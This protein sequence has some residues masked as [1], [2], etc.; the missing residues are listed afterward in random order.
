[1]SSGRQGRVGSGDWCPAARA[2]LAGRPLP[3]RIPQ[4]APRHPCPTPHGGVPG[5]AT[6]LPGVAKSFSAAELNWQPLRGWRTGVEVPSFGQVFVNDP[7]QRCGPTGLV[8][9]A[10]H[11]GQRVDL[12]SLDLRR[13]RAQWDTC[14]TCS[15]RRIRLRATRATHAISSPHPAGSSRSS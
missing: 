5:L 15:L 8:G 12:G 10:A 3:D 1:L 7:Q 14:S 6:S 2:D 13:R 4:P 11:S 9:R